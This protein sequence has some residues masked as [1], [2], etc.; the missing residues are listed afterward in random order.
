LQIL[1]YIMLF[2]W[3]VHRSREVHVPQPFTGGDRLDH[4]AALAG[5]MYP[6]QPQLVQW[7]MARVLQL[8]SEQ[9]EDWRQAS[10]AARQK[11]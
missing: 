6:D 1:H 9:N 11:R 2:T 4:V 10:L 3:F 7:M 8:F 5:T